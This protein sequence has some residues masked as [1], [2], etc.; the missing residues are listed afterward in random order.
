VILLNEPI[1][2]L[3]SVPPETVTFLTE[4]IRKDNGCLFL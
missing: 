4:R 1:P 3:I 2:D